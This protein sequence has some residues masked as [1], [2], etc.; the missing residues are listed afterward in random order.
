MRENVIGR[1]N[2]E[3]TPEL[4]RYY[5]ELGRQQS[6]ALWSVANEIEPW[7]PQ[8]TSQPPGSEPGPAPSSADPR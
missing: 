1:A 7:H 4:D 8:P 2:V 5:A 6:Y 3:D